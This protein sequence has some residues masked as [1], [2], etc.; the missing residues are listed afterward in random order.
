M[1]EIST[2]KD[3]DR[4]LVGPIST[5]RLFCADLE[6]TAD[7]Y[8]DVLG[9]PQVFREADAALFKSGQVGVLIEQGDPN[10][11]EEAA[12]I[13]RFAGISFPVGDM[14]EAVGALQAKGVAFDGE[15]EKQDWGGVLAHFYDPAGNLLTLV[16][17]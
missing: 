13:G 8:Q 14:A 1:T 9:L 11:A 6:A 4:P 17:D 10:S 12:L 2:V 7:F 3:G 5:V 16:Q 15:P